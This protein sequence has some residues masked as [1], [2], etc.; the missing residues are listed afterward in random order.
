MLATSGCCMIMWDSLRHIFLD[1]GGVFFKPE[2][3]AMYS[4]HGGLTTIGKVSQMLTIMG[5]VTLATGVIW[6]VLAP[7]KR[8]EDKV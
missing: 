2:S 5:F 8:T 3:L 1:H 6:F 4:D 7:K